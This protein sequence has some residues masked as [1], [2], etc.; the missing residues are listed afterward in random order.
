[1]PAGVMDFYRDALERLCLDEE[2]EYTK[3]ILCYR[4]EH[5]YPIFDKMKMLPQTALR[6]L[7]WARLKAR[8]NGQHQRT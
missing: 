2:A 8:K 3:R 1:M 5:M 4:R 6:I 7:A